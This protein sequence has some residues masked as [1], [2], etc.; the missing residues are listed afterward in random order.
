[1]FCYCQST[2]CIGLKGSTAL[3]Q[4]VVTGGALASFAYSSFKSHPEDQNQSLVD[5]D[6]ALVLTPMLLLGITAGTD[7]HRLLAPC[8]IVLHAIHWCN[9]RCYVTCLHAFTDAKI[10]SQH[11]MCIALTLWQLSPVI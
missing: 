10:I 1:M 7:K 4:S 8:L 9:V 6:L 2:A 3:S 5:F 11:R